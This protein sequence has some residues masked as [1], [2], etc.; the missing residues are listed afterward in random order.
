MAILG[1]VLLLAGC[2][3]P[4]GGQGPPPGL[5]AENTQETGA[6]TEPAPQPSASSSADPAE[7]RP[8]GSRS[9][10]ATADAYLSVSLLGL[11]DAGSATG[12]A[13]EGP[14]GTDLP[15]AAA[16]LERDAERLP[17]DT[18]A[19]FREAARLLEGAGEALEAEELIE[20]RRALEPVDTWLLRRCGT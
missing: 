17:Q 10:F 13:S 9:C 15:E 4:G 6:G 14:R 1:S 16:D 5:R 18:R 7:D 3:A 12:E 2:A 19:S 8:A 20:I 11:S